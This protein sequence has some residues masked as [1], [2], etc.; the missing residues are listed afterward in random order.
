MSLEAAKRFWRGVIF[1]P[2][3]V[4]LLSY[5]LTQSDPSVS[6]KSPLP[7]ILYFGFL[8]VSIPYVPFAI[9]MWRRFG[10]CNSP[11]QL[12]QV[13]LRWPLYFAPGWV[14]FALALFVWL[15]LVSG[16]PAD[17]AEALAGGSQAF[18]QYS[19]YVLALGYVY[20]VIALVVF[21][22]AGQL[23]GNVS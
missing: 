12:V 5:L 17:L 6:L 3:S 7:L 13:A 18:A 4:A 8:I 2:P 15:E 20:Q 19:L 9:L 23:R 11:S 21:L 22:V 1:V 10:K 16:P 14:V